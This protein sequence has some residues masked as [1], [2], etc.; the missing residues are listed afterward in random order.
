MNEQRSQAEIYSAPIDKLREEILKKVYYTDKNFFGVNKL[1]RIIKE[2]YP[3]TP[4]SSNQISVWL[5]RQEVWQLNRKVSRIT[6]SRPIR[7]SK[8]KAVLQM[9]LIDF[10]SRPYRGFNY[11]LNVVDVFSRY[12]WSYPIKTKTPNSV[13]LHINALLQA[14]PEIKVLQTD[15]GGEFQI[16]ALLIRPIVH[17]LS[18]PHNP[19]NNSQIERYNGVIQG[20]LRKILQINGKN[21]WP[22]Q[23]KDIAYNL[24]NSYQDAIKSTPTKVLALNTT[25]L[26][27]L[28]ENLKENFE[29]KNPNA[30]ERIFF[31]IG[32]KARLLNRK[33]LKEGKLSQEQFTY[34][35][36]I[37]TLYKRFKANVL[38][39]SRNRYFFKGTD[40]RVIKGTYNQ[41]EFIVVKEIENAPVVNPLIRRRD[42]N[43]E[44]EESE[45]V[46]GKRN[47]AE[48]RSLGRIKG[49][50]GKRI[51]KQTE[52]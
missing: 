39:N 34:S 28:N 44:S 18:Q 24:N 49:V 9:D 14:H 5:S 3:E 31:A 16:D 50:E 13:A 1:Y 7:S 2:R 8:I 21:D 10:S 36:E 23:L 29:K 11:I 52:E 32:T 15:N 45:N 20:V 4:I 46:R 17:I 19:T 25:Q 37:F 26:K 40:G 6:S 30:N 41:N 27:T 22:L 47:N 43:E 33:K 35:Q 48:V 51:R 38:T 12:I 42:D